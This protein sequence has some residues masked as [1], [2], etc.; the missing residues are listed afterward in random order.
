MLTLELQ[1]DGRFLVR[2][3]YCHICHRQIPQQNQCPYCETKYT[4]S[5][6]NIGT[7]TSGCLSA[8]ASNMVREVV[9]S[10]LSNLNTEAGFPNPQ[11]TLLPSEVR[12]E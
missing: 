7:I 11:R 9:A 4:Y 5:D 1:A 3:H 2:A 6:Q 8:I 10:L 12:D